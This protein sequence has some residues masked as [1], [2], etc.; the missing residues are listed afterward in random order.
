MEELE[1]NGKTAML[2][3]IDGQYAGLIAVAD[4]IKETSK[5]AIE[6]FK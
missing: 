5:K 6:A 1:A 3:S 2:A 4:T